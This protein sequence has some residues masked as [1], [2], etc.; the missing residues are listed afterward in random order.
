[1]SYFGSPMLDISY[2][3]FSSP[4][5]SIT[6][7]EFEQLLDYYCDQLIDTLK[8]LDIPTSKIPNKQQLYDD[9]NMRGCYGA[10]FC[11]FI[12]PL[13]H[14]LDTNNDGVQKFLSKTDEGSA[15]RREIFADQ[16]AQKVLA[17]LLRYF[18]KKQFLN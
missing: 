10:F 8:T 16:Q 9:F 14:Y 6:S 12:V 18:N 1:M 5:E 15:F 4:N 3:L 11:L 17:N 7:V 2:L 13:R